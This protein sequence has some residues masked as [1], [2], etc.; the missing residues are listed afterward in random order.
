MN[1]TQGRDALVIGFD[2]KPPV[3]FR[4]EYELLVNRFKLFIMRKENGHLIWKS[5]EKGP[6]PLPTMAVDGKIVKKLDVKFSHYKNTF[7]FNLIF[8]Q[9]K[10]PQYKQVWPDRE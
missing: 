1:T 4:D 8:T 5:I 2:Q 6:T 3:L 7:K 9:T 10:L